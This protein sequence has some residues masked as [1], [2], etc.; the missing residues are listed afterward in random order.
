MRKFVPH[1]DQNMNNVDINLVASLPNGY[2]ARRDGKIIFV[3]GFVENIPCWDFW[4]AY[5]QYFEP[6]DMRYLRRQFK[7][8]FNKMPCDRAQHLVE[9]DYESAVKLTKLLGAK[10]DGILEKYYDGDDYILFSVVK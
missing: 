3:G 10:I 6:K 7:K 1:V 4:G 5:S 8:E 9:A 2:C